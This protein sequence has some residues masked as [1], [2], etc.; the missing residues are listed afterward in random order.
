MIR[1]GYDVEQM[2]DQAYVNK[3]DDALKP[4]IV[5]QV[6]GVLNGAAGA[7]FGGVA[8]LGD[9]LG[10][11][12][13]AVGDAVAGAAQFAGGAVADGAMKRTPSTAWGEHFRLLR[14]WRSFCRHIVCPLRRL[15]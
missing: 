14:P 5:H 2:I 7:V 3:Q 1:L 10:G 11:A 15:R 9:F 8:A 6:G 4:L 13:Q 12:A